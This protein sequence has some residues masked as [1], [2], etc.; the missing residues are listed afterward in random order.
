MSV[1]GLNNQALQGFG[2][3]GTVPA[4]LDA[5]GNVI[6][7]AAAAHRNVTEQLAG[8][9]LNLSA[10][11]ITSRQLDKTLSQ[12]QNVEFQRKMPGLSYADTF[13]LG[14]HKVKLSQANWQDFKTTV[15]NNFSGAQ[16]NSASGL[17]KN[18]SLGRYIKEGWGQRNFQPIKDFFTGN[19]QG[20]L[21]R[22]AL[23]T[24]GVGLVGVD[25]LKNTHDAYQHAKLQEDGS[26]KSKLHTTRE[27]ATAFGKYSVRDGATWEAAGA[28]AALG[29]ALIP[30]SVGGVAIGGIAMGALAAV[31]TQ[32]VLNNVL[33]TGEDDPV[34]QQKAL[35]KMQKKEREKEQ[36]TSAS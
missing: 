12:R 24:A 10:K 30:L 4:I 8:N 14:E 32:K 27:T 2:L 7:G 26:M 11:Q 22:N 16:N 29:A 17:P 6:T 5:N 19:N 31:G 23:T 28:G 15:A 1:N 20:T 13:N 33:G 9:A 25:V 34:Q 21:A 3:P 35:E 36:K 18:L